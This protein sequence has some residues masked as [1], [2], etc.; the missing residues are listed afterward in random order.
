MTLPDLNKIRE[1]IA[2]ERV[3]GECLIVED[4]DLNITLPDLI[5]I[6]E[7]IAKERVCGE[8]LIEEDTDMNMT[9]PDLNENMEDIAEEREL[10]ESEYT[11]EQIK[12]RNYARAN[13]HKLLKF[14]APIIEIR[15]SSKPQKNN[16]WY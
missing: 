12:W 8:C 6:R 1:D 14:E 4:T 13:R 16:L 10:I 3:C 9:L 15:R 5:K 11:P 2:K 7:Y